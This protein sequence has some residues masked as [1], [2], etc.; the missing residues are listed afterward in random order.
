MTPYG[1]FIDKDTGAEIVRE[2]TDEEYAELVKSHMD[3]IVNNEK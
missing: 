2:M 1:S 3:E